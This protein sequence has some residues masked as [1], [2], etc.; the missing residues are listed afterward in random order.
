MGKYVHQG[1][2]CYRPDS[3]ENTLYLLD[4][5]YYRRS[6]TANHATEN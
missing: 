6:A 5:L 1:V 4:S 2:E 3:D